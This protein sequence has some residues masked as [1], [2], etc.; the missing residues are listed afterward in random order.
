MNQLFEG[1]TN[2]AMKI[3]RS[4]YQSTVEFYRDVLGMTVKEIAIEHPTI[5]RT[6]QVTFGKNTLWLDC[7]DNYAH[8]ELWLELKTDNLDRAVSHL[9]SHRTY[10]CDELEQIPDGAHWITDPAGTVILLSK[11]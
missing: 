2:I 1:G 11:K 8:S 6:H 4:K 10:T 5:S 3:P 9:A 7:V